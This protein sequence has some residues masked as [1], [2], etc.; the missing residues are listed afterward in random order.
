MQAMLKRYPHT[1]KIIVTTEVDSDDGINDT[2]EIEVDVVGRF[3][4]VS[5]KKTIDY[6]AKYYCKDMVKL[7]TKLVEQGFFIE[8]FIHEEGENLKPFQVDGHRFIFNGKQFK[9]VQLFPYQTHC[10]IWLE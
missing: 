6:S 2:S 10:E 4:P 8:G 9:I 7:I 1:A 5:Q 3:E